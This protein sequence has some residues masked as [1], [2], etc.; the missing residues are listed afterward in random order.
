VS[1][2]INGVVCGYHLAIIRPNDKVVD[3]EFLSYI[4]SKKDVRHYFYTLANGATRFG[5]TIDSIRNSEIKLPPIDH[6]KKIAACLSTWDA[7]IEA[8]EE[9]IELA[10]KKKKALMQKLLTGEKRL[11]GFEG[12]WEEIEL[13]DA[14]SYQQPTPFLVKSTEYSDDFRTPVLTAGKSFLLGYTDETFGIYEERLP[15]IIFDDFTT[16]SQL[17]D[18]PFK[19]KSSAMKILKA[20]PG[21]SIRFIFEAMQMIRF[22]FGVHKRHWI[23]TFANFVIPCPNQEE[24]QA[25]SEISDT[26]DRKIALL[27]DRLESLRGE[28]KALMQKLLGGK[29]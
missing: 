6:Q 7:A 24:Q 11:P 19:A 17:V 27:K 10:T 8:V 20:K 25:I 23:S 13:C 16:A 26:L 22:S 12:E 28:K 2:N 4:F 15:V 21:Y 5:L 9:Q 1:E 29:G 18:F 14:L 3:G